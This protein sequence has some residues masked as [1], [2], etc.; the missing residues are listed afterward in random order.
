MGE[1]KSFTDLFAY[2]KAHS[3]VLDVYKL[4]K[5]FP[6][7]ER[8]GLVN[9]IRRAGVSVTSNIAEG[10]ARNTAKDKIHFYTMS[11]GSL[12]ELHSQLLISRDLK[13]LD[14]KDLNRLEPNIIEVSKLI[15]GIIKSAKDY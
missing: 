9:Q 5:Y 11:R 3:L 2:K 12:L 13:Y 8:F 10:F 1:I 14:T 4:T 7:D 6:S 15:S